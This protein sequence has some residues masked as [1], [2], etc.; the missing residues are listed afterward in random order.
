V[1]QATSGSDQHKLPPWPPPAGGA[2][3]LLRESRWERRRQPLTRRKIVTIR[4]TLIAAGAF[5]GIAF[6]VEPRSSLWW[7]AALGGLIGAAL[8]L[9][10]FR[11]Y[12]LGQV[13]GMRP[14][15]PG[16]PA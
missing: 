14:P 1:N 5:A 13:L 8:S 9:V 3:R 6:S 7:G 16:P 4:V 10:S 11:P 15:R 2:A 12:Q